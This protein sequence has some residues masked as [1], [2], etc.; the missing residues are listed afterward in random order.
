MIRETQFTPLSILHLSNKDHS[1]RHFV[2]IL[3]DQ[4]GGTVRRHRNSDCSLLTLR[5][6][7]AV[8]AL[9]ASLSQAHTSSFAPSNWLPG[10][11]RS[12]MLVWQWG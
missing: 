3:E 7:L 10:T 12:F 1:L 6:I 5:P 4:A 2:I 11:A 8:L 9:F